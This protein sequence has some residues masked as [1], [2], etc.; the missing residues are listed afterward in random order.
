MNLG[1][2]PAIPEVLEDCHNKHSI[3]EFVLLSAF[4]QYIDLIYLYVL[5]GN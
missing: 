5:Q 1:L 2:E 3:I 4:Q